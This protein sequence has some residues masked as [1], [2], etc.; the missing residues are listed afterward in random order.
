MLSPLIFADDVGGKEK[1]CQL[2]SN[3]CGGTFS[4]YAS[5]WTGRARGT[6]CLAPLG[7]QFSLNEGQGLG[8]SLTL[9][10][11]QWCLTFSYFCLHYLL[12][13]DCVGEGEV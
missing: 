7:V 1:E 2:L 10:P 11:A 13:T 8:Y 9:Y 6:Y 3:L 4:M 12:F 5:G